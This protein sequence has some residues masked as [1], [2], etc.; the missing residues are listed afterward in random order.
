MWMYLAS[1]LG[2]SA[3]ALGAYIDHGLGDQLNA[4]ARESLDTALRYQQTHALALLALSLTAWAAPKTGRLRLFHLTC[5][6]MALG[7]VFFSGSL[8]LA[9]MIEVESAVRLTPIG[10]TLLMLSWLMLCPLAYC[11]KRNASTLPQTDSPGPV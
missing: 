6:S 3:I 10:G 9:R 8:Y 11:V 5:G 4:R 2:F 7:T 1:L